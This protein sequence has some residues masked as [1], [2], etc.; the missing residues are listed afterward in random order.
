MFF[1]SQ[2]SLEWMVYFLPVWKLRNDLDSTK[3]FL[4]RSHLFLS[5]L[6]Q[7]LFWWIVCPSSTVL[8]QHCAN[9]SLKFFDRRK[10]G[11]IELRGK[12][13]FSLGLDCRMDKCFLIMWPTSGKFGL[14]V[15][16]NGNNFFVSFPQVLSKSFLGMMEALENWSETNLKG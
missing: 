9:Y 3:K 14:N 13:S 16:T 1:E 15:I 8:K 5:H 12:S 7:P 10:D 4:R 11:M 2:E 6:K